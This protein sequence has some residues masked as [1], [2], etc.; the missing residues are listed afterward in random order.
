MINALTIIAL[1]ITTCILAIEDTDLSKHKIIIALFC[2][3]FIQLLN[4]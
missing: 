4:M 2:I 1:V 3:A